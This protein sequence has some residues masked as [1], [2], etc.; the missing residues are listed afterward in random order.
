[1]RIINL[2]MADADD[3]WGDFAGE[4]NPA[5]AALYSKGSDI[6]YQTRDGAWVPGKVRPNHFLKLSAAV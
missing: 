3:D 2:N 1:V 5:P 6:L 4:E